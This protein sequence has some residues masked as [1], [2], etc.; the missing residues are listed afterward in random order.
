MTAPEDIRRSRLDGIREHLARQGLSGPPSCYVILH[1]GNVVADA[2]RDYVLG[3]PLLP[4][5]LDGIPLWAVVGDNELCEVRRV[6][7]R[8]DGVWVRRVDYPVEFLT[9]RDQLRQLPVPFKPTAVPRHRLA[10]FI[11]PT[12]AA[13]IM[14]ARRRQRHG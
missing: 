10:R 12:A 7:D 6:E 8:P 1:S 14:H 11:G 3:I 9:T 5:D 13:S 2:D 4:V